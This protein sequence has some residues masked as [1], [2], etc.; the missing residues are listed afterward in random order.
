MNWKWCGGKRFW[1]NL[2]HYAGICLD[3]IKKAKK[4]PSQNS[5]SPCQGLHQGL[6]DYEAG[7]LT[8]R[9]RRS[10]S[11]AYV[12][13]LLFHIS[14]VLHCLFGFLN[15]NRKHPL[16]FNWF[17][18]RNIPHCRSQWPRGLRRRSWSLGRCD[19]RFESRSAYGCWSSFCVVVLACTCF[20]DGLIIRP[21][22]PY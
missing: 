12:F 19:H 17:R 7:V 20:C 9:P 8:T 2:R 21:K 11:F 14:F 4:N 6:S 1:P 15:C 10:V 3:G 16:D 5:R 13:L 18:E 22:K